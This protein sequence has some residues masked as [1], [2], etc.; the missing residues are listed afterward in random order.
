MIKSVVRKIILHMGL[1]GVDDVCLALIEAA[2]AINQRP[3]PSG[4]SSSMLLFGQRLKLYGE[5]YA[6]GAPAGHHPDADDPSSDLARR[7]K[8][9]TSVQQ[10]VVRH[11]AKDLVRKSVSARTRKV[12]TAEAGD[13]VFFYRV[14]INAKAKR[15][16]AQRGNWVGRSFVIGQ[17]GGN[18]WISHAGPCYLVALE[19]VRGLAPDETYGLRP[20]VRDG[21][22][23]LRR[24]EKMTMKMW[25]LTMVEF[26]LGRALSQSLQWRKPLSSLFH[27]NMEKLIRL[28]KLT[29]LQKLLMSLY[30]QSLE[31]LIRPQTHQFHMSVLAATLHQD[32]VGMRLMMKEVISNG[33][34]KDLFGRSREKQAARQ[35]ASLLLA[36]RQTGIMSAEDVGSRDSI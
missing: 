13:V 16:Q 1:R 15:L 19:H 29:R 24:A 18:I 22:S 20:L 8:I 30:H 28:E 11:H 9:R 23:A 7:F 14:Y 2:S 4:V 32:Q 17:P 35:S 12:E 25:C 6:Q 27:Q 26:G 33:S 21:L 31:D 36:Q 10:A 34:R 5:L 3:G